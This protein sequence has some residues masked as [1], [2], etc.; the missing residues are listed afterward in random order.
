MCPTDLIHPRASQPS[1]EIRVSYDL[2]SFEEA[3]NS[4]LVGLFGVEHVSDLKTAYRF[5]PSWK[6]PS[7]RLAERTLV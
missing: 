1:F 2:K 3:V 7:D 5:V 6:N 4:S